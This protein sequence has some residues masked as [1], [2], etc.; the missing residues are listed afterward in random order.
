[1]ILNLVA[2]RFDAAAYASIYGSP[3]IGRE[4]DDQRLTAAG[5]DEGDAAF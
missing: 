3:G 1:V 5:R 4:I 2:D